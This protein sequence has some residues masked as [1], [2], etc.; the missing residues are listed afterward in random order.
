MNKAKR[1]RL[2]ELIDEATIDCY[3]EDEQHSGLLTMIE[4]NVDCPFRARIV[5]EE[6]EVIEFEWPKSGY[7]LYA[8]CE[9]D[10]KKHRVDINSLEW[11]KPYPDGFEW[12]EAYL[13]WREGM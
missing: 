4:D 13:L 1:A 8:I 9:R 5:G 6:V 3:G 2:E 11:V 7:G 12:I 10:G